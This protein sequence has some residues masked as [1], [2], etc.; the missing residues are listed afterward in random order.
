MQKAYNSLDLRVMNLE[1]RT[2]GTDTVT[3]FSRLT[4]WNSLLITLEMSGLL[5][6]RDRLTDLQCYY[7]QQG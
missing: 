6:K 3:G 5:R 7:I 2:R 1:L 4:L